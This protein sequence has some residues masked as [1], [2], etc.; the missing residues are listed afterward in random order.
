[1]SLLFEL[2]KSQ[3][4]AVES[5]P[6]ACSIVLKNS[7]ALDLEERTHIDCIAAESWDPETDFDLMVANPPYI[8]SGDP[9]VQTSVHQHEPH[10]AL[11][12]GADG[13]EAIRKWVPVVRRFLK[14]GGIAVFEIGAGQSEAVQE[15]MTQAGLR[16]VEAS[17]DLAGISRVISARG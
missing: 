5:S 3:L 10:A 14:S 4:W 15:I 13:L 16:D 11:Y 6:K 8:P 12:S 9:R 2:T 7:R 1:L 17:R